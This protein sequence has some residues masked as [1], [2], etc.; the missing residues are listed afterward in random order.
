MPR[1]KPL[2][3]CSL[4]LTLPHHLI[5]A[6]IPPEAQAQA[7]RLQ[8][9]QLLREQQRQQHLQQQMQPEADVRSDETATRPKA[10]FSL[11]QPESPCFAVQAVRLEGDEARRFQFALRRALAE[12]GFTPGMCLGAQGINHI[13]TLAQNA[14]IAKGYTTTRILAAPQDLNSGE[15]VLTV[16]PGR[17]GRIRIEGADK[18]DSTAGRIAAF[19]NEFPV[20]DGQILNLRD[21]EQG[22]ENLKRLPTAEADIQIAPADAPDSSD[23]VV[24]WQQRTLPWRLSLSADDSG[25]KATGKYQGNIAFSADNPLGM[26]DLFYLSYGRDLGHKASYT[27]ADGHTTGSG[28][29]SLALHYSVP[30]GNWLWALNH[31]RYRYHQAVAGDSENYDYNGE[32]INTDIG[33]TRLLYRDA[34]RKSHFSAKLWKRETKSYINDAEIDVQRRQNAGWQIGLTHKEYLGNA[35][36]NL[37]AAYKRGTGAA[38]SLRAPEERYGEGSSRMKILTADADLNLPFTLCK[39]ALAYDTAIHAQWNKSPLLQQDK[40]AIGN[41]YTVRGFDGELTLAAERGWYWRND[42]SWQYANGHLAYIGTDIGHVS[43]RSA[44]YLLGQT[45]AGGVVGLKGQI[46][47]GGNLSYDVF[48]GK[49]FKKPAGFQT[50]NT[51]LGF[52]LNYAF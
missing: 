23:V 20:S 30:V 22:L 37:A 29:K 6:D 2:A 14:V 18:P 34:R 49:P 45:L 11:A 32:S 31:N 26:S 44:D 12:S 7:E 52:S 15:L 39:Q 16:I 27:D 3:L 17:I 38:S 33:F 25:S 43:G 1:L 8:Q 50:A 19:Q 46:K 41:R 28:S 24:R 13:M 36:L 48:A 10:A 35:T 51:A 40:L 9:Q 42:L 4:L 47:A 21:L 5:A